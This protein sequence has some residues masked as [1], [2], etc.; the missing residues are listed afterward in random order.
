MRFLLSS[1]LILAGLVNFSLTSVG[2]APQLEFGGPEDCCDGLSPQLSFDA[3]SHF[4]LDRLLRHYVDE[5]GQ[6]CYSQWARNDADVALL[7]Q[8][9]HSLGAV[10]PNLPA[11]QEGRMAFYINAYNALTLRGM[12][13]EYPIASI[14][15]VTDKHRGY[16]IF[17][18]LKV[19]AAGECISLNEIENDALRPLR[20][21]RIHFA[22]VCAAKG[23]PRLLNQAYTPAQL[24]SLLDLNAREFFSD[25]NRFQISRTHRTVKMSPILK[26]YREDFGES[27][28]EVV[29]SVFTYLPPADQQ[30][31]R[32]NPQWAFE[33]MG[34][35]WALND[36][37]P[38]PHV[39]LAAPGYKLW[40]KLSPLTERLKSKLS[41]DLTFDR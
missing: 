36:R 4:A 30:W 23:C 14:Q 17:D 20:D 33:Y 8:Y 25:P 16:D 32:S 28:W 9:L 19:W 41:R 7:E 10:D 39:M 11:S 13:Q 40:S 29:A 6:V 22:L 34:Y 38:S 3:V 37:C 27:D 35:N 5:H 31:L 1:L 12:L 26:W 18:D 15:K 21:P 24:H 2:Q